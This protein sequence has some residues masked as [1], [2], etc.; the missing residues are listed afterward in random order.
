MSTKAP[1]VGVAYQIPRNSLALLM[2][3]Q[4]VVIIPHTLQLSFWIVAVAL[5]CGW[6]RTQIYRG[7]WN[8]PNSWVR[9][10]LVVTSIV[11]V[12]FGAATDGAMSF[13][14]EAATSLLVLA[15]ALK[16]LEMKNRR[17]AYL[18]I[19]LSY[20][21]IST[22]FLFD[23]SLPIALYEMFATVVVT[24]ALVGLHQLHSQVRPLASIKLAAWLIIQAIPLTVV[25]FL[26]FPRVGPIWSV[27]MPGGHKTGISEHLTPGD[28]AS[29]SQSDEL[30]FRAVFDSRIPAHRDLYWRGLVYSQFAGG[31]WSVGASDITDLD[32]PARQPEE[33]KPESAQSI[34]QAAKG[35]AS[36]DYQ[37]MLQPTGS[38]WLYALDV[39]LPRTPTLYRT[40][41]YRLVNNTPVLSVMRYDVRSYPDLPMSPGGLS[42][43]QRYVETAL[44][45]ADNPRIRELAKQLW[46]QTGEVQAFAD[47]VAAQIRQEP[48]YYTLQPPK[49]PNDN[50][51]DAFWFDTKRGFCTHYAGALVFLA[52]SVDIPA[53]MVG[54]Y[55]GGDINP[56]TGH[57]VV[58]QYD[59]HAWVELWDPEGGWQRFDPT[60]AV[61]PQRIEEGLEA[62]LSTTDRASL[63]TLSALRLA[64]WDSLTDALQ[65]LDSLEHRWNL[66]VVGFDANQQ[67]GVLRE[68]LGK[69]EPWRIALALLFTGAI[70]LGLAAAIVFWRRRAEPLAPEVKLFQRFGRLGASAGVPRALHEGPSSYLPRLA[71]EKG[72]VAEDMQGCVE[73]LEQVM[74]NTSAEQNPAERQQALRRIRQQLRRVQ[75]RLALSS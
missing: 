18:V 58:R 15:F 27:P 69:V 40:D 75:V 53:R 20:F 36:L 1:A 32:A 12:G 52:R 61:A 68:L 9:A 49:L 54:G 24:A 17:D 16:L 43:R 60:A 65:W 51:I 19:F 62:A 3:A 67:A 28:V 38:D 23:Q 41:D 13:S 73:D 48:F 56:I 37:V 6:W 34:A 74:Y 50:S 47:A 4:L 2:V 44:P 59:A 14:L 8:Y 22:Q 26:L 30:A 11:G 5:F 21:V 70:S 10:A 46:Q 29:L 72:L 25:L 39:A 64:E 33:A 55:Q 42:A 57:L 63:P 66:W 71:Q 31:T 7:R 45:E 35:L